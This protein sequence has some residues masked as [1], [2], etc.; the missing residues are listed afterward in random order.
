MDEKEIKNALAIIIFLVVA[1]FL[2]VLKI[3]Y[4]LE[5]FWWQ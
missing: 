4:K 2:L 3:S 5:L 1:T